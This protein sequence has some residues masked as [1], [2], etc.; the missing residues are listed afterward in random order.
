MAKE[1]VFCVC[2]LHRIS[3]SILVTTNHSTPSEIEP[4]HVYL[5]EQSCYKQIER[6]MGVPYI[7]YRG[8]FTLKIHESKKG[9]DNMDER[10]KQGNASLSQHSQ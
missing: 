6:Y 1:F 10:E 7:A 4:L 9:G 8:R 3:K 5:R 2:R